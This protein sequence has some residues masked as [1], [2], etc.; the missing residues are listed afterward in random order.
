MCIRDSINTVI[1]QKIQRENYPLE[2]TF[3]NKSK[4][5]SL[6]HLIQGKII[7]GEKKEPLQSVNISICL[8]Y[9]SDAADERSSVDLGGRRIIKKKTNKDLDYSP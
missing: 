1:N 9:T 7:D 4:L 2:I 5:D 3:K 6:Q 8:L